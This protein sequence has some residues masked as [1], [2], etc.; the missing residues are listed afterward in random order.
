MR[1]RSVLTSSQRAQEESRDLGLPLSFGPEK[2]PPLMGSITLCPEGVDPIATGAPSVR[3]ALYR[4][5]KFGGASWFGELE[6]AKATK[7]RMKRDS[8]FILHTE[9]LRVSFAR[10]W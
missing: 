6:R 8:S 9:S 10:K 7:E 2:D 4:N 5:V 1:Y 3:F